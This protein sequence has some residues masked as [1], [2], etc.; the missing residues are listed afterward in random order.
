MALAVELLGILACPGDKGALWYLGGE[1]ALVNP[2]LSRRY[3]I[4]D[5]IPVL[6]IDEAE[7]LDEAEL[8]RIQ[9]RIEAEGIDPTFEA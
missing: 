3:R 4:D 6:L 5:D 2:R 1:K 9:G 7:T 8:S